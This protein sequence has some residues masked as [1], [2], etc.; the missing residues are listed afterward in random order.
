MTEQISQ[1]TFDGMPYIEPSPQLDLDDVARK[2]AGSP[3]AEKTL[4]AAIARHKRADN[5]PRSEQTGGVPRQYPDYPQGI[6]DPRAQQVAAEGIK[7]AR[8]ALLGSS[9]SR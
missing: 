1:L 4:E 5:G 3:L 9:R 8:E 6:R 7:A 2:I